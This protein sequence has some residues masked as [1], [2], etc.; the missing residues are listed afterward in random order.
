MEKKIL[1]LCVDIY[2]H[3]EL[4][5]E[6]TLGGN[7]CNSFECCGVADELLE[8]LGT[9]LKEIEPLIDK[10]VEELDE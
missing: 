3:A 9:N 5:W 4:D 6:I 8:I 1:D 2:A 7:G 10:R